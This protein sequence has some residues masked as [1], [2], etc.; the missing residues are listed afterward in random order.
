MIMQK[1]GTITVFLASSEELIHDRNS[2][3]AL[4]SS[5]DDIYDYAAKLNDD[6]YRVN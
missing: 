3:Q 4:I 6:L 5:L 2:F 1:Q